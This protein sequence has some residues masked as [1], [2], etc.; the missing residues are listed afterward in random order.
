MP[1]GQPRRTSASP[2][3][4][5]T[6]GAAA[7]PG[8]PGGSRARARPGGGQRDAASAG[9]TGWA[10]C[11]T[12]RSATDVCVAAART[13]P[14]RPP[15]GHRGDPRSV[16]GEEDKQILSQLVAVGRP[17]RRGA[18]LLRR[19]APG[20]A[21]P[22]AQ[23]PAGVPARYRPAERVRYFPASDQAEIGGDF[24][25]ALPGG[26]ESLIAIGDVQGHS[27]PAATIMGELRHA[28]R[29]FVSEGHP[30]L[31]ITGLVN[32]VLRRYH[33][34]IIATLC[35]VARRRRPASSRSSTAGTCRCC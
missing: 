16:S 23:L 31:A 9:A 33:P 35:L 30:P 21:D 11:R 14:G 10:S 4:P 3:I 28:L 18:A 26:T 19:G 1:D 34:G 22:A 27:L 12:A 2:G 25:E 24:Y 13:K 17:G 6:D 20:R 32:D 29:A 5:G 15:V 8:W 7:R